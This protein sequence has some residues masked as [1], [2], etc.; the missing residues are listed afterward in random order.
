MHPSNNKNRIDGFKEG[1]EN[2]LEMRAKKLKEMAEP[3]GLSVIYGLL[4]AGILL[5]PLLPHIWPRKATRPPTTPRQT[6]STGTYSTTTPNSATL[7][8]EKTA[9]ESCKKC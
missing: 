4:F 7:T 8:A 3:T 9:T 2:A 6:A 1:V 5:A